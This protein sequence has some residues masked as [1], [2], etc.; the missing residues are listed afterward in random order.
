MAPSNRQILV[1]YLTV[2]F[3]ATVVVIEASVTLFTLHDVQMQ[4]DTSG[5][6]SVG[7]FDDSDWPMVTKDPNQI[8]ASIKEFRFLDDSE[9]MVQQHV[10][11]Q[12]HSGN[13]HI[14]QEDPDYYQHL[15]V[16]GREMD[17]SETLNVDLGHQLA[18][19]GY[20][21]ARGGSY[22]YG[23]DSFQP[24]THG[25]AR[26]EW[27]LSHPVCA[28]CYAYVDLV[29]RLEGTGEVRTSFVNGMTRVDFGTEGAAVFV[30]GKV[31]QIH[32]GSAN[33]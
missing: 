16:E 18:M 1:G 12:S 14:R 25:D 20:I 28:D 29:L 4:I 13:F 5:K 31:R 26:V 33:G 17:S 9:R 24:V 27:K 23:L 22:M 8:T 30:P 21:F 32:N 19:I 15:L 11:Q 10:F 6:A 7:R 2:L 3:T